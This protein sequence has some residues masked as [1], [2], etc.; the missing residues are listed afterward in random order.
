MIS[1]TMN[2]I[3][4]KH[5]FKK[6]RNINV[7]ACENTRKNE[8]DENKKPLPKLLPDVFN[9]SVYNHKLKETK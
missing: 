2:D 5:D 9:V 4:T 3:Y 7:I 1:E 8:G 6:K